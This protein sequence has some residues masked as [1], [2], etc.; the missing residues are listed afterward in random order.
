MGQGPSSRT[1]NGSSAREGA[2]TE[3]DEDKPEASDPTPA[4]HSESENH[5]HPE[6]PAEAGATMGPNDQSLR[7]PVLEEGDRAYGRTEY[8]K[9]PETTFTVVLNCSGKKTALTRPLVVRE[10]MPL[11]VRDM[12]SCI[13]VEFSIPACCQ[14]LVFESVHMEDKLTLGFYRVRDGD[15][16]QVNYVSEGNVAEILSV[17]SHMTKSYH[18]IE[19]IQ[20][21]LHRQLVSDDL[22]TLINQSVY[23]EKVNDLPEVYFSPCSSDK[24]EAN[25]NLFIQCG[26]LD[27]LQRLHTLLLRQP[28][29][30]MPLKMQY[31]EHSILRAYW[32]ITAA[33][34]VR[35]Y[36]LQYPRALESILGSFLRV[37]L[38]EKERLVAPQNLFTRRTNRSELNRIACEVVYKA[39]GALCK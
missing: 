24:A 5:S 39:M 23:W 34:T 19:S 31:L 18:F 11:R 16:I 10:G 6:I 12:K 3:G 22:D 25:R 15:T 29:R 35:L 17:V 2:R 28:W 1:V 14:S 26:G 8:E 30:K 38:D 9:G 27:M 36:V 33:F 4:P 13:E 32:N 7:A 37:K 21:D 20:T